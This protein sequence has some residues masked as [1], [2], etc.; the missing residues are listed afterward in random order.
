MGR[1]NG[2][3]AFFDFRD[4]RGFL[5]YVYNFRISV[6]LSMKW[7]GIAR[8]YD[9]ATG[10]FRCRRRVYVRT[11]HEAKAAD[12]NGVAMD[13]PLYILRRSKEEGYIYRRINGDFNVEFL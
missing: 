4:S 2:K 3:N 5:S 10:H 6:G 1:E 8:I 12:K 7:V 11:E 13:K 9:K